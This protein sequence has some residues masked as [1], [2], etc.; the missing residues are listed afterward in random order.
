MED[1]FRY[2][3]TSLKPNFIGI[4]MELSYHWR[5]EQNLTKCST[6]SDNKII[7]LYKGLQVCES[8]KLCQQ[9]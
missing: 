1:A 7:S 8:S 4:G 2:G 9:L 5:N 3:L 6:M